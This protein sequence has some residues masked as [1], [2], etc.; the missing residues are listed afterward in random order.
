MRVKLQ[1]IKQELRRRMHWPIPAQ[2]KWLKQIIRGYFNYHAVPTNN[3]ALLGF[4]DEIVRS[5][6]W[7]LTRRSQRD[8]TG[9][10]RMREL[11]DD[12]LPKPKI[13]HPWPNQRFAVIHLR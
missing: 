7:V 13:L 4:R 6:R 11:A 9:W 10:E 5:W 3:R 12:W 8:S 2:G 1:A